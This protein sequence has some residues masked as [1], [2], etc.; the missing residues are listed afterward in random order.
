MLYF[1]L[2][3]LTF[4]WHA[5]SVFVLFLC[6]PIHLFPCLSISL[7]FLLFL[8]HCLVF[9]FGCNVFFWALRTEPLCYK[10]SHY[11]LERGSSR[12]PRTQRLNYSASSLMTEVLSRKYS[13]SNPRMYFLWEGGH[14][15]VFTISSVKNSLKNI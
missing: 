6:L 10:W 14:Y 15:S 4:T 7:S 5:F 8:L 9:L 13:I 1:L 11:R 2:F 3:F 12:P